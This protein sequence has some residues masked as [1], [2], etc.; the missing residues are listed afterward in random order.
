MA[1]IKNNLKI[2]QAQALSKL[3]IFAYL[4]YSAACRLT[5]SLSIQHLLFCSTFILPYDDVR[6]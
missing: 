2:M 4:S 6:H 5:V 3:R 1:K